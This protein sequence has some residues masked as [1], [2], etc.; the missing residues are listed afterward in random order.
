[1][2]FEDLSDIDKKT[3]FDWAANRD[4]ALFIKDRIMDTFKQYAKNNSNLEW[5]PE[6]VDPLWFRIQSI[7]SLLHS[8]IPYIFSHT[9]LLRKISGQKLLI[10]GIDMQDKEGFIG[11]KSDHLKQRLLNDNGHNKCPLC[12]YRFEEKDDEEDQMDEID[13]NVYDNSFCDQCCDSRFGIYTVW[14]ALDYFDTPFNSGS[15]VFC[16]GSHNKYK[17]YSEALMNS[18]SVPSGYSN[19]SIVEKQNLRWGYVNDIKPGDQFIFNVKTLHAA[20]EAKDG[21]LRPRIDM[22]VAIRP[23]MKRYIKELNKAKL[24]QNN[25]ENEANE[26]EKKKVSSTSHLGLSQLDSQPVYACDDDDDENGLDGLENTLKEKDMNII[27]AG[28]A[29]TASVTTTVVMNNSGSNC[30]SKELCAMQELPATQQTIMGESEMSPELAPT[31]PSPVK[32]KSLSLDQWRKDENDRKN[33]PT[34]KR[35]SS[36]NDVDHSGIKDGAHLTKM[37]AVTEEDVIVGFEDNDNV[38]NKENE[39]QNDQRNRNENNAK[40]VMDESGMDEETKLSDIDNLSMNT[41]V[42]NDHEMRKMLDIRDLPTQ[43]T[44][45]NDS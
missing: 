22:R 10:S 16:L 17:G 41:N 2:T 26:K 24:L 42:S 32:S 18:E 20:S 1:M 28:I 34:L 23:S 5:K 13:D 36:S 11:K 14:T 33:K 25:K 45:A 7:G 15:M 21:F 8:D 30:N 44:Q 31:T 19:K 29:N 39:K 43:A 9:N 12:S 6:I 40:N 37:A 35:Y 3:I 27:N 38:D 4:P